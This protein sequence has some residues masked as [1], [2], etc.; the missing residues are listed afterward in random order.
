MSYIENS[1]TL[2]EYLNEINIKSTKE[3]YI[4]L[5]HQ[6][7]YFCKDVYNKSVNQVMD[8]LSKDWEK[9]HKSN[10]III[11]LNKFVQWCL[12]DHP[13]ITYIHGKYNNIKRSVKAKHPKTIKLYV[14][15]IRQLLDDVWD[16]EVNISKINR[17]VKI[18]QPEEE[19]PEPFTKKQMRVFLDSLSNTK[20]LQFMV[21]KDTGMRIREFCQIRKED[22]DITGKRIKITIQAK[23]TKT[24]KTRICHITRETEPS[25]L[26][27]C[28][29][30]QGSELLFGTN[31]DPD[32]A[33]G[34]YQTA[35]AYYRK[36]L[37]KT[38]PEFLEI[39][40]HNGRHKK[41]IHSIRSYSSTQ[42]SIAID[43]T[44]GHEYI[45]HKKYLGQYIRNQ[46][47]FLQK[48]IRSENRL[49]VYDTIEVVNSDERVAKLE[50]QQEESKENMKS[51]T[52]ILLQ[53]S[54]IK[55]DNA[56]KD[57]EIKRLESLLKLS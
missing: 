44:W 38:Y 15:K 43:E 3:Q 25:L 46:N 30:K 26:R 56:R 54:D 9:T 29:E 45:G 40:Q 41:T 6:F 10:K 16:V 14:N 11:V 4:A 20:K 13:E 39:H 48:F 22:V 8:D 21:L 47:K 51:L 12:C 52:K 2:D 57:E 17:K 55:I 32:V 24:K 18:P 53:M 34:S 36:R 31:E 35:F 37:G 1:K 33:K 28:K 42:C 5:V 49:M 23:Y 19:D 50:V 7:D 27:L